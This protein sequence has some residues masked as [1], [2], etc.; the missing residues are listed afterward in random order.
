MRFKKLRGDNFQQE[1][2][3]AWGLLHNN[4]NAEKIFYLI[5]ELNAAAFWSIVK[6]SKIPPEEAKEILKE[7]EDVSLIEITGSDYDPDDNY[8]H[9]TSLGYSIL[10]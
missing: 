9:I 7:L 8:Y 1:S 2:L 10:K 5:S 3:K 6:K 4:K